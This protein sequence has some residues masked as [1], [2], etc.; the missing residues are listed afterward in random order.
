M[1][2]VLP[3]LKAFDK[4]GSLIQFRDSMRG[5]LGLPRRRESPRKSEMMDISLSLRDDLSSGSLP[6]RTM[7]LGKPMKKLMLDKMD[8]T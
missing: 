7:S 1:E 6:K 5:Y 8:G 2:K 4:D 3:A